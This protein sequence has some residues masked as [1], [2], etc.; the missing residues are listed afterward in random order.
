MKRKSP[1]TAPG[2]FSFQRKC[3]LTRGIRD[4]Q[5]STFTVAVE[6]VI[7]AFASDVVIDAT[8]E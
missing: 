6:E 7:A 8:T 4:R 3:E 5:I 1:G 2:L